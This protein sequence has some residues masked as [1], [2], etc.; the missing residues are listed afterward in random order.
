MGRPGHP[1]AQIPPDCNL[2][3]WR[4]IV[5][6]ACGMRL[7]ALLGRAILAAGSAPRMCM[8]AGVQRSFALLKMT[9]LLRVTGALV[10]LFLCFL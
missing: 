10:I 1:P 4:R 2:R 7:P 6:V 5:R 8:M 3:A 9:G